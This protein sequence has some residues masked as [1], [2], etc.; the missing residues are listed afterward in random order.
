MI[1]RLIDQWYKILI[2]SKQGDFSTTNFSPQLPR[3]RG[4]IPPFRKVSGK[5]LRSLLCA[6][7]VVGLRLV[8]ALLAR[9]LTGLTKLGYEIKQNR[10]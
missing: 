5:V 8:A 4:H 3:F 10:S 9:L 6:P 7:L 2:S 1:E